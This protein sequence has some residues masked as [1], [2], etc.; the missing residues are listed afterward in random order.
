[1]S[2]FAS[3][4]E[5]HTEGNAT[6]SYLSSSGMIGSLISEGPPTLA[7]PCTAFL[8]K[9]DAH[10]SSIPFTL[11]QWLTAHTYELMDA[12]AFPLSEKMP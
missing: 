10:G 5:L 7:A 3:Y 9:Y 2:S 8:T 4:V 12:G 6:M 1:M 11:C